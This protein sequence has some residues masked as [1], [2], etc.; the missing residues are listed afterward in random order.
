LLNFLASRFGCEV[1]TGKGSEV[2]V[3]RPGS[4]IFTLGHHGSNDEVSSLVV[5]HMLKR[6]GIGPQEWLRAVYG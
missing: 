5:T 6:L 2:K 3:Y 4:R 1:R